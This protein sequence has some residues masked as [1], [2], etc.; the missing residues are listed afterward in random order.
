MRVHGE[1][2]G[3]RRSRRATTSTWP[4]RTG[5]GLI[6]PEAAGAR[7]GQPLPLPAGRPRAA[8]VRAHPVGPR[9]AA[10]ASGFVP[11]IPPVLVKREAMVGTGFF[12]EAEA[13]VYALATDDALPGR[14]GRG[15]AGVDARRRDARRSRPAAALRR[16]LDVLPARGRRGGQGHAR[17]LPRAPVRQARALQLLPPRHVVGRAGARCSRSRRR[18]PRSSASTTRWSNI[19]GRRPGRVGG[20]QVRHR[21]VAARPGAL[22]R[23]DLVLELHRLPGPAAEHPLPRRRTASRSSCTC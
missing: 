3:V 8:R 21:G 16:L 6:D 18:S 22:P 10:R 20:A 14:H 9:E 4:G 23:A 17:D 19:A 1:A 5:L 7:L 11:V 12:P 15:A 2:A 13:Q